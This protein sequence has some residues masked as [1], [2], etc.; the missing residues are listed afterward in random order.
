MP[1]KHW[2]YSL[3]SLC[4]AASAQERVGLQAASCLKCMS[5]MTHEGHLYFLA[6][7]AISY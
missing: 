7:L 5:N 2:E 6:Y 3:D 1:V 4:P